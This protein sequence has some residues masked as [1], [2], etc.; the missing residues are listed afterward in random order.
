[1]IA[2][3]SA[4]ALSVRRFGC[5]LIGVTILLGL[6]LSACGVGTTRV[7]QP[8]QHLHRPTSLEVVEGDSPV[9]VPP[10]VKKDFDEHLRNL[11]FDEDDP[12]KQGKELKLVYRFVQFQPGNQFARWFLKGLGNAG[13]GSL[14]VEAKYLD[15]AGNEVSSILAGGKI[16]S[17]IF[18][19]F[20]DLAVQKSAG[21]IAVYTKQNFR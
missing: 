4:P 3:H 21:E 12:F 6:S 11:L 10:G 7:V 2:T 16:G 8:P 5:G 1:M 9:P 17:G 19:G 15:P 13:E 20:Y 14:T 18:G